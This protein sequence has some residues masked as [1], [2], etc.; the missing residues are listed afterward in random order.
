MAAIAALEMS[1]WRE[2]YTRLVADRSEPEFV[3]QIRQQGLERFEALGI[4]NR[5]WESWRFTDLAG[6][7]ESPFKRTPDL[8]VD[9][10]QL[11]PMLDAES[12]RLVFVNGRYTPSLS[13]VIDL[14]PG[15]IISNLAAAIEQHPDL[16]A[17]HLAKLPGLD[18]HPF[19]ALNDAM[20]EDGAFVYVPA[21]KVLEQAIHLVFYASGDG[22]ANYPRN[23]IVVGEAGQATIVEDYRGEG[24]YF[25]C[26]STE[27]SLANGAVCHFYKVQQETSAAYHLG[28]LRWHLGRDSSVELHLLSTSGRINRNDVC[29][30]MDG[31]GADCT[32]NGLILAEDG[33]LGDYH[34]QVIHNQP[35]STSQQVFK[36]VLDGKSRAVFDGLINVVK[37]AQKTDASQTNRNLLLSK[38][39]LANSNPRLEILA[40]DVKCAHGST[41]GFLDVDALFYL[42]SRGIP[43]SQAQA[44][45][46][47]AFANEQVEHI[48][49]TPL[50]ERLEALMIDRYFPD[51]SDNS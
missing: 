22:T 30:C 6:F 41:V 37:D 36:S 35:H 45:L 44:M 19:S 27:A 23:L 49:L 31:E 12:P 4:P 3:A 28:N 33:E 51:N 26:P 38:Q 9:A 43:E 1:A 13:N 10:S 47:Y 39:A 46:V 40:D 16:V 42:R 11:P 50:R 32:I 20:L 8:P 7:V 25:T 14:P 21:G 34:V 15:I 24:S 5:R 48:R 29:V 17:T 18:E 2:E